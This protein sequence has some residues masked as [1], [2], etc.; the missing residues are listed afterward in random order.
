MPFSSAHHLDY[1]NLNFPYLVWLRVILT[2]PRIA[3]NEAGNVD[4]KKPTGEVGFFY[5]PG[6]ELVTL[7]GWETLHN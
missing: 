4:E 1:I 6:A 5:C 7:P 3:F 2:T